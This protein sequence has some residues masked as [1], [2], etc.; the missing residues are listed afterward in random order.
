MKD[1][2]IC[3]LERITGVLLI[4]VGLAFALLFAFV[5]LK[6]LAPWDLK[7]SAFMLGTSVVLLWVGGRFIKSTPEIGENHV[8]DEP[9]LPGI[10][11]RR[12]AE[13]AAA[14]GTLVLLWRIVTTFGN[15]SWPPQPL[16]TLI[17]ATPVA[18][19]IFIMYIRV[20]GDFLF[21]RNLAEGWSTGTKRLTRVMLSTARLGYP[22]IAVA[23]YGLDKY[24]PEFWAPIVRLAACVLIFILYA[25]QVSM[26]HFGNIRK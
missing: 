20:P 10:I 2:S 8:D 7:T 19:G 23:W 25:A 16:F 1:Q 22:A 12:P 24:A 18:I 13:L 6:G 11:F 26:L 14:L 3:W 4:L 5:Q 9:G 21:T 17:L 15:F